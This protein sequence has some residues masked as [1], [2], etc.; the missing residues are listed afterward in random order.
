MHGQVAPLDRPLPPGEG[1]GEGRVRGPSTRDTLDH[2]WSLFLPEFPSA[3]FAV[4]KRL[5]DLRLFSRP[6]SCAGNGR[7]QRLRHACGNVTL[8]AE[9]LIAATPHPDPLPAGEGDRA[10]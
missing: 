8:T 4:T 7:G 2:H 6:D 1:R 9:W 3:E 5:P 10:V